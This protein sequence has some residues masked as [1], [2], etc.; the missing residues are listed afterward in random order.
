[1][2]LESGEFPGRVAPRVRVGRDYEVELSEDEDTELQAKGSARDSVD[3]LIADAQGLADPAGAAQLTAEV[4]NYGAADQHV[5][6]HTEAEQLSDISTEAGL[7]QRLT[8]LLA[9]RSGPF[10]QVSAVVE[11]EGG[12]RVLVP[13]PLTGAPA[14]IAWEPGDGVRR[15]YPS[16]GVQDSAG[17]YT[18]MTTVS[19]AF[20]PTA[21]GLPAVSFRPRP[22]SFRSFLERLQR[23]ALSPQR[24]YQGQIVVVTGS[25]GATNA[26]WAPDNFSRVPLPDDLST[27]VKATLVVRLMAVA[28][29][30]S[31]EVNNVARINNVTA[32]GRYDVTPWVAQVSAN[33]RQMNA[34]LTGGSGA[35]EITLE[36]QIA[37]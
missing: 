16:L 25:P 13:L 14:E 28:D 32:A 1:M 11:K 36:L 15:N 17:S 31:I 10:E 9:L 30:K 19:R 18:Q 6:V 20:R 7:L 2:Q 5:I 23:A 37:V 33:E 27:V 8:A 3:V 21:H 22:R 35:W 29:A 12:D 24:H 34:R 4:I 26:A